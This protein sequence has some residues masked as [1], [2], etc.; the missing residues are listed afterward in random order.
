MNFA[1]TGHLPDAPSDSPH[2]PDFLFKTAFHS[3][4]II[5]NLHS[6]ANRDSLIHLLV[7]PSRGA[8]RRIL[9]SLTDR[10]KRQD[11]RMARPIPVSVL[12]GA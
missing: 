11:G 12:N 1:L 7:A 10:A 8:R 4:L 6:N 5:P 2:P 9:V 3:I